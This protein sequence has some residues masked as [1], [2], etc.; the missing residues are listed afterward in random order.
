MGYPSK[1]MKNNTEGDLNYGGPTQ[2]GLEGKNI[3]WPRYHSCPILA[4]MLLAFVLKI[5]VKLNE[6]ILD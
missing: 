4:R 2:E 1:R 6:R 5:C 3:K